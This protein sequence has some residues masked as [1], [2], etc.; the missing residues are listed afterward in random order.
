MQNAQNA[1][2]FDQLRNNM[3]ERHARLGWPEDVL[4]LLNIDGNGLV[5]NVDDHGVDD[6]I[7]LHSS[8][9]SV[10]PTIKIGGCK[11]D[12]W[13]NRNKYLKFQPEEDL[14]L[15]LTLNICI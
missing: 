8:M 10:V 7:A 4:N 11:N 12:H 3:V 14:D 2:I 15:W 6:L 1:E 5:A 13:V 9:F